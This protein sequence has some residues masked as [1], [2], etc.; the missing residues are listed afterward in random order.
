MIDGWMGG[1]IRSMGIH[2][3]SGILRSH[4]KEGRSDTGHS[5]AGL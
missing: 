4:E 1:R 2:P 3:L 5:V